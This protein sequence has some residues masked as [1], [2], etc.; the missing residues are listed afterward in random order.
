MAK[1]LQARRRPGRRRKKQEQGKR[2]SW[3]SA[4]IPDKEVLVYAKLLSY[5][6]CWFSSPQNAGHSIVGVFLCMFW[7]CQKGVKKCLFVLKNAIFPSFNHYRELRALRQRL[8]T[9]EYKFSKLQISLMNKSNDSSVTENTCCCRC[10]QLNPASFNIPVAL[11]PQVLNSA[12]AICPPIAPPPP[13]APPAPPPPPPLPPVTFPLKKTTLALK[14]IES[15]KT[16]KDPPVKQ[17]G[18]VHITLKDLLKV[19]LR[20][21]RNYLGQQNVRSVQNTHFPPI[22]LSDIQRVNLKIASKMPPRRLASIFK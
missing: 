21:T 13:P 6:V 1:F 5:P 7:W 10:N 15:T 4:P 2:S 19:K 18:P 11:H 17:D 9:L 22:S 3:N 8:Q 12:P 14:N 20:K 16:Q